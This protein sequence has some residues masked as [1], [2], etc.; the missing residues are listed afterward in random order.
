MNAFRKGLSEVGM[1]E[2]QNVTIEDRAADGQYDRLPAL[3]AELV[4]HRV[5]VIAAN[6]LPAALA[7]KAATQTI[8]IVFLS[9]SDPIGVGVV[10]S[11]NRPTGNVSLV[12][13]AGWYLVRT[14]RRRSYGRRSVDKAARVQAAHR[15][16]GAFVSVDCV[17]E[18]G[19]LS[20]LRACAM[21]LRPSAASNTIRVRFTLRCAV[22]G[23][24]HRASSTLRIFG[25]SRTSLALGI[26]PILN[27]DSPMEKSGH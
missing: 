5:A 3:A 4:E 23:A 17:W 6:F 21:V 7:A 2:G 12:G 9:G 16:W 13:S 10:S 24:R 25:V 27:H 22:L 14:S 11:I 15:P 1:I 19:T 20:S 18:A 26:V 8:P